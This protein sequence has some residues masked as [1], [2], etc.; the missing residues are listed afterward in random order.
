MAKLKCPQSYMVVPSD[1]DFDALA[2]HLLDS[3]F[4]STPWS[5][6]IKDPEKLKADPVKAK[7][8]RE[9]YEGQYQQIDDNSLRKYVGLAPPTDEASAKRF[10]QVDHLFYPDR[11]LMLQSVIS[12]LLKDKRTLW[13]NKLSSWAISYLYGQLMM[14]D[15]C[16]DSLEDEEVK[17]WFDK[18][19]R[20]YE[21]GLDRTPAHI[22]K[23]RGRTEKPVED[24]G[25]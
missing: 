16:L 17:G 6:A 23:R 20:R 11:E 1:D 9:G 12:T 5:Y 15:D 22:V 10:T 14:P 7:V 2:Q 8:Y 18:Q 13:R 21:G 4:R 19:I 24:S 25:M 3:G